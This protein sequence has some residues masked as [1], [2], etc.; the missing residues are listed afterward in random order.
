MAPFH[1]VK[2]TKG[3]KMEVWQAGEGAYT[4]G[5]RVHFSSHAGSVTGLSFDSKGR[6]SDIIGAPSTEISSVNFSAGIC[7]TTMIFGPESLEA[8]GFSEQHP[9]L[10]AHPILGK[11]SE[12]TIR[13][14][15]H[16]AD[17]DECL[18]CDRQVT[19]IAIWTRE[20]NGKGK[21]TALGFEFGG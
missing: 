6:W 2:G 7:G 11:V 3:E 12:L 18:M 20:P 19:Q 16:I 13:T 17:E 9:P 1:G 5:V 21:V 15:G 4:C 8:I 10:I 14:P